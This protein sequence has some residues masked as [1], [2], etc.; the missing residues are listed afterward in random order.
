MEIEVQCVV[1][2]Q[3]RRTVFLTVILKNK[4]INYLSCLFA[5]MPDIR[6]QLKAFFKAS[7][8]YPSKT[9]NVLASCNFMQFNSVFINIYLASIET[10]Y[11]KYL[12]L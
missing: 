1:S 4:F 9:D 11:I 5:S 2:F 6:L 8:I 12:A 10:V 3:D 7:G